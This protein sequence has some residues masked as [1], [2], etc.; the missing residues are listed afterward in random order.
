MSARNSL[1]TAIFQASPLEAAIYLQNP[2][3]ATPLPHYSV[4]SFVNF[5]AQNDTKKARVTRAYCDD[6]KGASKKLDATNHL[7]HNQRV[8]AEMPHFLRSS[9]AW[10]SVHQRPKY[11]PFG[12][13]TYCGAV[14]LGF[15]NS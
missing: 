1:S 15:S 3:G 10:I 2:E 8:I 13:L 12:A 4:N 9:S 6:S 7:D 14:S 5:S 11:L